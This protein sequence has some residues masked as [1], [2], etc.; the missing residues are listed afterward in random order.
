MYYFL[1]VG[2]QGQRDK[3]DIALLMTLHVN[4]Q[5]KYAVVIAV[6]SYSLGTKHVPL[7]SSSVSD[8][9]V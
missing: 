5:S 2:F 9:F 6:R 4:R 8:E 7:S 3:Q 1:N